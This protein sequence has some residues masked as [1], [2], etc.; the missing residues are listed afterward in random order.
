[1]DAQSRSA[2]AGRFRELYVGVQA[3]WLRECCGAG[4]FVALG[5]A[6]YGFAKASAVVIAAAFV[7]SLGS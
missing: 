2:H 3:R 6:I 4:L 7:L 5:L 1:M